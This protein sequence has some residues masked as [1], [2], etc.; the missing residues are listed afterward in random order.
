MVRERER[1]SYFFIKKT[2]K[3]NNNI[4]LFYIKLLLDK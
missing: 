2:T 4:K 3:I 1:E